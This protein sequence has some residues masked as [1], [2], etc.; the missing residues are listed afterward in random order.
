MSEEVEGGGVSG[1]ERNGTGADPV[2]V[3][4]ALGGAS[5][6]QA[7]A[8][9]EDQ[10]SLI[11]DQKNLVRLQAKELAHELRLRHWSLQLRHASAILKFALEVSAALIG[12]AV[13]GIIAA[14]RWNAAHAD[15]LVIESF[16]VPPDLAQRG[17]T[18]QVVAGQVLDRLAEINQATISAR[19]GKSYAANWG[20]DIKVEIPDTGVSVAEAYRFLRGWLGHESHI[21]GAVWREPE[22]IVITAHAKGKSVTV[23]GPEADIGGQIRKAAEAVFGLAEPYRY[24]IYLSSHGR[25]AEAIAVFRQQ[26]A[27]GSA[28]DRS[29][30]LVG[31]A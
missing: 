9:L 2:A 1:P 18:G 25:N 22:G 15:G 21:S 26:V 16:S 30:G 3:S 24:G 20:D 23:A 27:S 11:A 29:W 5:Q 7:D 17:L 4:L 8:F 13:A 19:T 28:T 31:L 14:A 10:R 6:A 12:R